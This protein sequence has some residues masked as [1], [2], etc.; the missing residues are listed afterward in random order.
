MGRRDKHLIDCL[1]FRSQHRYHIST[2]SFCS[3]NRN[4]HCFGQAG[5]YELSAHL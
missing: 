5:V 3:E 2:L 4:E 1:S